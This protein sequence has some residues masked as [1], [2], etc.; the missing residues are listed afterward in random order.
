M[1]FAYCHSVTVDHSTPRG[2]GRR[3]PPTPIC[4]RLSLGG[5]SRV[6]GIAD[7]SAPDGSVVVPQ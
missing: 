2:T 6:V 7:W 3:P 4:M 5:V 1:K